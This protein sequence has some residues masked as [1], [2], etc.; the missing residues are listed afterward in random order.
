SPVL[1][2]GVIFFMLY[3]GQNCQNN[4][5]DQREINGAK[6][7]EKHPQIEKHILGKANSFSG[8]P[9]E[10]PADPDKHRIRYHNLNQP[11]YKADSSLFSHQYTPLSANSEAPDNPLSRQKYLSAFE[12]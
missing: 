6:Q 2:G 5:Y 4:F 1:F 11:F 3:C 7:H 9:P 10:K 8:D 12:G